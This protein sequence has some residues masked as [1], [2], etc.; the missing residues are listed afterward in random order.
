MI[1][2]SQVADRTSSLAKS[3]VVE[4]GKKGGLFALHVSLDTVLGRE[5][6]VL[7]FG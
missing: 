6:N 4:I 1:G 7:T 2:V 3:R 5:F